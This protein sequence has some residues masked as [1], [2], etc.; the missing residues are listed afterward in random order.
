MSLVSRIRHVMACQAQAPVGG[1]ERLAAALVATLAATLAVWARRDL[2]ESHAMAQACLAGQGGAVCGVRAALVQAFNSGLLG[3]LVL[4]AALLALL[5]RRAWTAALCL[6]LG[7][8]G[9]VLYSFQAGALA[10]L[11]GALLLLPA[12]RQS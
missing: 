7:A 11:L 8:T 4:A 2:V 12:A 5:C 10:L 1:R 3:A 6:T 9:L